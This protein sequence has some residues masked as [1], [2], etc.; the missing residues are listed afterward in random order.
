MPDIIIC[1]VCIISCMLKKNCQG[2]SSINT[3]GES[4]YQLWS[5]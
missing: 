5:I 3:N 1:D 2:F 4:S